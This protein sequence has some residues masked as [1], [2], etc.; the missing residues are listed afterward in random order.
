ME[1][2][3]KF[4]TVINF[5]MTFLSLWYLKRRIYSKWEIEKELFPSDFL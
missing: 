2:T 5:Y 3:M 1:F 4:K